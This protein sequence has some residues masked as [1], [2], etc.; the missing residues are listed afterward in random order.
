MEAPPT[1]QILVNISQVEVSMSQLSICQ[2][3]LC[4]IHASWCHTPQNLNR[5]LGE[6]KM[7][8]MGYLGGAV[9]LKPPRNVSLQAELEVIKKILQLKMARAQEY[10]TWGRYRR[11][12]RVQAGQALRA[13]QSDFVNTTSTSPKGDGL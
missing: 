13:D 10:G 7:G 8:V 1:P 6:V 5:K 3:F 4:S 2:L 11:G 12:E 9:T